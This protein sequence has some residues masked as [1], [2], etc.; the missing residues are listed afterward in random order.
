MRPT[1]E[2][3]KEKMQRLD[4]DRGILQRGQLQSKKILR[5]FTGAPTGNIVGHAHVVLGQRRGHPSLWGRPPRGVWP[6]ASARGRAEVC[7][8]RIGCRHSDRLPLRLQQSKSFDQQIRY[9]QIL[10]LHVIHQLP[11]QRVC[12]KNKSGG[13]VPASRRSISGE[14][15]GAHWF[16]PLVPGGPP[17]PAALF[18]TFGYLVRWRE[19][20]P[21]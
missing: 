6:S 13:S 8:R 11:L 12:K 9:R 17:A 7:S 18:V 21:E 2:R 14:P 1:T 4:A 16:R 19:K 3:K 15:G 5:R 20:S 10:A